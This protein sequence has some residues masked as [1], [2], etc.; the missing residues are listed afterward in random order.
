M[1]VDALGIV[2]V[3][4]VVANIYAYVPNV[5]AAVAILVIAG[6]LMRPLRLL[7]EGIMPESGARRIVATAAPY[8]VLAI[9]GFMAL[10]QLTSRRTSSASPTW[11]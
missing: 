5:I 8:T 2:T 10:D 11:R 7:I 1:T 4:N 3:N 6:L 9:G